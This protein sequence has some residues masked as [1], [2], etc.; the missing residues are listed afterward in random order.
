MII[1]YFRERLLNFFSSGDNLSGFPKPKQTSLLK[2]NLTDASTL[3][4]FLR[5]NMKTWE[6]EYNFGYT[7]VDMDQFRVTV[8]T[9]NYHPFYKDIS[10]HV[11]LKV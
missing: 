4:T 5:F 11:G 8:F 9:Q 3:I 2:K 1:D 6:E 10:R 7:T